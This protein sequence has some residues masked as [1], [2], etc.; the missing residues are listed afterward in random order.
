MGPFSHRARNIVRMG[1]PREGIFGTR[2]RD[3]Y[4]PRTLIVSARLPKKSHSS[5]LSEIAASLLAKF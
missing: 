1:K 3:A 4:T 2:A 5:L